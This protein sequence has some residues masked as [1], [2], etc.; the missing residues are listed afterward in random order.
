MNRQKVLRVSLTI[1]GLLVLLVIGCL[2]ALYLIPTPEISV[3]RN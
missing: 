3:I 2:V 1:A